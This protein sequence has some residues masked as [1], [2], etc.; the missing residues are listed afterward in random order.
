[1]PYAVIR[2]A[3]VFAALATAVVVSSCGPS[4]S[5]GGHAGHHGGHAGHHGGQAPTAQ[6][7]PHSAD[8]VA[9][10]RNM[11]PHHQ[12]ALDMAA[13][14]PSRTTDPDMI[15]LAREIAMDQQAEIHT[16]KGLLAQWG[17]PVSPDHGGSVDHS[18][19]DMP[20]MQ[21]MVDNAT[22]GKL[23]SLD[24]AAFDKLWVSAMI[25]HHE[26]AVA[27]AQTE[28]DRGQNPDAVSLAKLIITTQ[29]REIAYMNH[30]LSATQ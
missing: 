1:V 15:V 24:G 4:S 28:V 30:R 17:E 19:M 2:A 12:Q 10:A 16:L 20:P 8:D 9:F 7:A 22:L 3:T 5:A 26:G 13:M 11:I 6:A 23:E 14:V 21:G 29:Q 25:G 27:M 18:G